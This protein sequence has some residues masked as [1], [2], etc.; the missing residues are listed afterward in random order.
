MKTM[1]WNKIPWNRISTEEFVTFFKDD[2][3]LSKN[4]L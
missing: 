3:Y 2:I 4:D 1:E